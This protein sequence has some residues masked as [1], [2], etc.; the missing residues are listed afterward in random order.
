MYILFL[1]FTSN[2]RQ[3]AEYMDSHKAWLQR[4]FSEGVFLLAGSLEPT[5]GG[6][7][8]AHKCSR[9]ELEARMKEDPF[10][11]NGV[12]GAEIHE[13]DPGR[14]DERLQFLLA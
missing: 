3:A 14:A 2:K 6:M 8:L 5:L 1:K 9:E 12:V 4:G 13:V 11:E 7:I 10:V